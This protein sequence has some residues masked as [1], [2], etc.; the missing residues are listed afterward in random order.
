MH[1]RITGGPPGTG[2]PLDKLPVPAR[3]IL[4]LNGVSAEMSL[5]RA[6]AFVWPAMNEPA[7]HRYGRV[8]AAHLADLAIRGH[9][10][11]SYGGVYEGPAGLMAS[12]HPDA[13]VPSAP[14]EAMLLD[15]V[16]GNADTVR[17]ASRTDGRSWDLLSEFT[18]QQL[19]ADGLA[20]NRRD[21]YRTVRLLL[22]M[23]RWMRTYAAEGAPWTADPRL[24]LVGYPYAVLFGVEN[25]P[26]A[27]P[28]PPDEE[29]Y[30]P[31][32]LPV[33]CTMAIND[34][35]PGDPA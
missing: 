12:L 35:H 21:R 1:T 17:L 19:K 23:R 32:L 16:F 33:A 2:V 14:D 20:C 11:L 22:R 34:L 4:M 31:S 9:L 18:H 30:L 8:V 6:G 27:W 26:L 3:L 5:L 10:W 13:P 29:V 7:E 15:V 28:T 24:H 25:G